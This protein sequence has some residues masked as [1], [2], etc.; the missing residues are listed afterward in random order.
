MITDTATRE[1][2]TMTERGKKREWVII[3]L[4]DFF[5]FAYFFFYVFSYVFWLTTANVDKE[6]WRVVIDDFLI[7][8]VLH[9]VFWFFFFFAMTLI[10]MV[11]TKTFLERKSVGV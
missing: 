5:F 11:M 2:D 6:K 7:Q 9:V 3:S 1:N 8:F 10:M 4:N